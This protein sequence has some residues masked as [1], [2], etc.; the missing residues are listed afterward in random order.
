MIGLMIRAGG[1]GDNECKTIGNF[2]PKGM[3]CLTCSFNNIAEY[4]EKHVSFWEED[5]RY[6]RPPS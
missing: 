6:E 2:N 4:I 1:L 5:K 3:H